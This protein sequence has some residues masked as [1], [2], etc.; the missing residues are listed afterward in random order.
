[1]QLYTEAALYWTRLLESAQAHNLPENDYMQVYNLL[2]AFEMGDHHV[3]N[4]KRRVVG[5]LVL[6]EVYLNKVLASNGDV[7]LLCIAINDEIALY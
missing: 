1:M 7:R 5:N 4:G 6:A 2:A 3:T